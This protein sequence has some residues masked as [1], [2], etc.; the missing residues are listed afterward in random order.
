MPTPVSHLAVGYAIASW[1]RI[2]VPA[3]RVGIVAAACAALPDI[4]WPWD[5]PTTSLFS[6]RA[7]THSLLFASLTAVLALWLC[8]P[9]EARAAHGRTILL[10]VLLAAFSHA[11]LDALTTYSYG[12]EFFAP[13]TRQRFRFLWTPLGSP[14][15]ALA[16]QL[17]QEAL[18][19]L[20]P[21]LLVA[22]LGR[23]FAHDHARSPRHAG[24]GL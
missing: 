17:Q 19:V 20:L 13:F 12:I 1:A 16:G 14:D 18:V 22:W 11:C 24:L 8:F 23:R 10:V 7:I 5:L 21:A 4:D 15:G 3:R 2:D 9:R 6:H